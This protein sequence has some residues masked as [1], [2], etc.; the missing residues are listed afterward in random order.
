MVDPTCRSR[1]GRQAPAVAMG[2]LP[3]ESSRRRHLR[4][5]HVPGRQPKKESILRLVV[6][7]ILLLNESK[8]EEEIYKQCE[9]ERN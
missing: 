9:K 8:K 5:Q 6:L 7:W 2:S 1:D 4:L 3:F